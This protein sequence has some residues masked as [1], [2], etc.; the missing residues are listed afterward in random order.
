[1][2]V[3]TSPAAAVKPSAKA[4]R[5][6]LE[7]VLASATFQQV[8]RLKR[9]LRFVVEEAAAG[10][11]DQLKEYVIGVQVFGKEPQFDPRTDPIVRVQAR[12]LRARLVRYAREE[13]QGDELSI[14]L[15]KGGYAPTF[16]R[17]DDSVPQ[18]K[19]ITAALT[20][21]NTIAVRPFADYSRGGDLAY[22]CQG[23]T[24]E[25]TH[26]LATSK[27]LRVLAA[28]DDA[29]DAA[30][31]VSGS[32]RGDADKAR[33]AAQ[34]VDAGSGAILWSES[35]DV[36]LGDVLATEER[37]AQTIVEKLQPQIVATSPPA[38]A[39]R[40]TANLAANNLYLQAR[41]HLN[42][43]TEEGLLKAVDLFEKATVEDAEFALAHSGLAD[44]Y[45]LLSH[46]GVRGPADMWAKA[47]SCAATAVM[48]APHSAE[49]RTSL[50]HVKG[51]QDW[52]WADA[53]REFKRAISLD[54]R[55]PTG[56]HWYAMS[57][58]VPLGR[59]DE[60]L[61]EMLL[62]QGLDPVSS[63]IARDVAVIHFYRR[64]F[65]AALD[66][67]DHAIELNPHFS[68]A[69]HTL[70]LVQEQR[71]ELDE[72][73][74][75][76]Q[77]AVHLSPQTPRMRGAL[78]RALAISGRRQLAEKILRELE[79]LARQ[80]YV[81]PFEFAALRFA[82]GQTDLAFKW[83]AKAAEDR[84][85]EMISLKIDPRFLPMSGDRRFAAITRKVGLE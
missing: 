79:A 46:Y 84:A 30:M 73:V 27:G 41:Y 16:K 34:L 69:Y 47:A 40:A 80:R 29:A 26:R 22:F 31:T 39:H 81:S 32:V 10:R 67:C 2:G 36:T 78:G 14:E 21:R 8:D 76:L 53:E 11:G 18:K 55:Y 68:P 77:R 20:N 13:G 38:W 75:A 63:I 56:H 49:A 23:L 3:R 74:A 83:L 61:D 64:D 72:S 15:P 25:V 5:G 35:L 12:R 33:I 44:A 6:Q 66:Q 9:F 19:S 50:A 7:R 54:P 24:E 82:L 45:G 37:V 58:L 85:F 48:L 65:A 28:R 4:I 62:A 71:Q 17:R 59:L 52:D 42:Q 43:R 57:C 70:G 60:A 1:M 51:S